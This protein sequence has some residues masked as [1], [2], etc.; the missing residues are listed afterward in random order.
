[1]LTSRA[2]WLVLTTLALLL[3]AISLGLTTLTLALSSVLGWFLGSWLEFQVRW[4]WTARSLYVER[5]LVHRGAPVT[6][7]WAHAAA[8][9]VARLCSD[10]R[11]SLPHVVVSDRIPP[12]AQ[13]RAG[14]PWGQGTVVRGQSVEIR[15]EVVC[16]S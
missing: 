4:H 8:T 3:I 11:V 12:L 14:A 2:W 16:P 5:W 13:W 7:L 6:S 9:M 15:Y 10:S 1:M